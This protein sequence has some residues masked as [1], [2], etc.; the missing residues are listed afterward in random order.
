MGKISQ[1][2]IVNTASELIAQTGST[3][4]SLSMIADALGITHGALYKHFASKQKI[5]EAVA[6]QWFQTEILDRVL[7]S[8]AKNAK[9]AAPAVQLHDWLWAFV[10]AKK[11]AYTADPQMFALNTR[12]VDNNPRALQRVLQP[13]YAHIDELMGYHDPHYERAETILSTLAV[14]ALPNFKDT[15]VWPDYQARFEAMWV[16]IS[17]GL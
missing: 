1:E 7:Q 14:F 3:D 2:K 13:A 4:I 16:L 17:P 11:T 5:W 15:W 9:T 8:T 12:Y 6:A 10:N